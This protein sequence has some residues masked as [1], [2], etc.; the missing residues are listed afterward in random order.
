MVQTH[1]T[2]GWLN[3]RGDWGGEAVSTVIARRLCDEAISQ[4]AALF[5][6]EIATPRS[7]SLSRLAMTKGTVVLLRRLCDEAISQVIPVASAGMTPA[8]LSRAAGVNPLLGQ[9]PPQ[10]DNQNAE[11]RS[12]IRTCGRRRRPPP[13]MRIPGTELARLLLGNAANPAGL[14]LL[15]SRREQPNRQKTNPNRKVR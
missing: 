8:S 1:F 12:D 3:W 11:N 7:Q 4:S 5:Y 14:H 15:L 10:T 9:L 13:T 6:S 2:S